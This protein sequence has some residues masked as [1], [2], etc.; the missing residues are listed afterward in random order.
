MTLLETFRDYS[1]KLD[2]LSKKHESLWKG[3]AKVY[4][5]ANKDTC[6]TGRSM[7]YFPRSIAEIDCCN[8]DEAL[9]KLQDLY[10][11]NSRLKPIPEHKM[12][13]TTKHRMLVEV[14]NLHAEYPMF[15][16]EILDALKSLD[17]YGYLTE[18]MLES[19]INSRACIDG[20]DDSTV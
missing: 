15:P 9:K 12:Y 7:M 18:A 4:S 19:I 3:F 16:A 6:P 14:H 2:G 10:N 1:S 8:L 13:L 17:T 11:K 5:K 20:H